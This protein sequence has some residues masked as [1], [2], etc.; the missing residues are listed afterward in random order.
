MQPLTHVSCIVFVCIA[1]DLALEQRST[2]IRDIVMIIG[3]A[4]KQKWIEEERA[5]ISKVSE[6]YH[7][8]SNL[9]KQDIQRQMDALD[10]NAID[11][12]GNTANLRSE[13]DHRLRQLETLIQHAEV[14]DE[15]AKPYIRSKTQE[16]PENVSPQ[17][18]QEQRQTKTPPHIREIPDYFLD[19]ITFEFMHDPVISTKSGVSYE[20]NTLLEH[21]GYGRMIDPVGQMPMTEWDIVPNRAL[22]EA[23]DDFLSKNGWAVD[24]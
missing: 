14:P 15:Y 1:Y 7:Y 8:L 20:R 4:K 18:K 22:K 10:R 9:I 17:F 2:F 13:K 21:F 3:E 11:Y 6:T 24:Y 19:K 5:R 12:E 23:C 16:S